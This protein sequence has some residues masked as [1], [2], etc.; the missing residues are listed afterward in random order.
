MTF[1]VRKA[2]ERDIGGIA[3]A[4]V[5]G[6]RETYGHILPASVLE[7]LTVEA[8]V[9]SW[10][11]VMG[12]IDEASLVLVAEDRKGEIVGFAQ[13]GPVRASHAAMFGTDAE[14][15]AVYLLDKVKRQG[16]GRTLMEQ[17]FAHLV[18]RGFRSA[19]LWVLQ[20]N[21]PARC[22]YEALGGKAGPEQDLALGGSSFKEI[23]YRFEPIPS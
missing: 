1:S 21:H 20:E 23:A 10:R 11:H 12:Q 18:Q 14:I 16:L 13:G 3:R 7:S 9:R 22:F 8:R 4:H 5:Q 17:V 15:H 2:D 19:G 6:W